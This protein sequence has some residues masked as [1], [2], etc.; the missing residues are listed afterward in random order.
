MMISLFDLTYIT[1]PSL[2]AL[3]CYQKDRLWAIKVNKQLGLLVIHLE[4]LSMSRLGH[5]G[6]ESLVY[7]RCCFKKPKH[8][9][10][11]QLLH[12]P[13]CKCLCVCFYGEQT[14]LS[15]KKP[16]RVKK[17]ILCSGTTVCLTGR[18][19]SK[20]HIQLL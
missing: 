14:S 4:A 2:K 8:W 15:S 9:K 16:L 10:L 20:F 12:L 7:V 1:S 5:S 17:L 19:R 6:S 3:V 13:L 11:N 18:C